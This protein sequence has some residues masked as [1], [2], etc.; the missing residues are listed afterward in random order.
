MAM[1][2]E[3]AQASSAPAPAPVPESTTAGAAVA[4]EG[5]AE[6]QQSGVQ[7]APQGESMVVEEHRPS[8]GAS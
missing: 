6:V 4:I 3:G 7:S 5:E 8:E 2:V 1:T